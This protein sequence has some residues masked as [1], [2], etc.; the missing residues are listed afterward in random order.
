[1]MCFLDITAPF[2]ISMDDAM[3]LASSFV[4]SSLFCAVNISC[5]AL[6]L[7]N[8]KYKELCHFLDTILFVIFSLLKF[9]PVSKIKVAINE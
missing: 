8:A 1:F 5:I 2:S 3:S 9:K 4:I 7:S 6:N